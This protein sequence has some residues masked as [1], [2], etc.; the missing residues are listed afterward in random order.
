MVWMLILYISL[1]TKFET[2]VQNVLIKNLPNAVLFATIIIFYLREQRACFHKKRHINPSYVQ[3]D[4]CYGIR[5]SRPRWR[6]YNVWSSR[7]TAWSKFHCQWK[8]VVF[9]L[10]CRLHRKGTTINSYCTLYYTFLKTLQEVIT[11]KQ[12]I[13]WVKNHSNQ[14]N[15]DVVNRDDVIFN[16][17]RCL[18]NVSK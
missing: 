15:V 6:W 10:A 16:S 14:W 9:H 4:I 18:F 3:Q 8:Q 12:I 11:R 2:D 13:I 17:I 1:V 5:S 7:F